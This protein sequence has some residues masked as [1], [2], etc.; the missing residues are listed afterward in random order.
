MKPSFLLPSRFKWLG[1]LMFGLGTALYIAASSYNFEFSFLDLPSSSA[2]IADLLN[3]TDNYTISFALVLLMGGL[4][5]LGFSKLEQE[6]EMISFLRLQ[7]LQ[8]S[9]YFC[10]LVLILLTAFTFSLTYLGFM[11]WLWYV[12]LALYCCLFYTKLFLLKLRTRNNEE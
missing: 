6:D 9:I 12:F 10:V 1:L 4:L 7:A 5:A 8:W 11:G 3:T 2:S